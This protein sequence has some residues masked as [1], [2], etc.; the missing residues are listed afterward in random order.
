MPRRFCTFLAF[1]LS[2]PG[3]AVAETPAP[4]GQKAGILPPLEWKKGTPSPF[5]RV[6]SPTA[7]VD[8]KIYLF[9]GFTDDLGAANELDVYDP[10]G[11]SWTVQE[12]HADAVH[13]P[14]P[15]SGRQDDLVRRRLPREASWPGHE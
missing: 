7:V 13:P 12:R 11:D 14:Q 3:I 8:G 1:V 10:A 5:A 9:G 4:A 6:E 15:G 2:F